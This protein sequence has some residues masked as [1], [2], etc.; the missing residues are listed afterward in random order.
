MFKV[1]IADD[2]PGMRL[3]L[4]KA[5]SKIKEVHILAEAESAD[6]VVELVGIHKPQAVFLDVEMGKK[7]GLEAAK[8][9]TDM[10]PKCMI[11]FVTAFQE[12][13]PEAFEIYAFDYL[14]KPFKMERLEETVKRMKLV[15]ANEQEFKPVT[16]EMSEEILIKDKDGTAFV[17][18]KEI[19]LVQRENRSTTIITKTHKYHTTETLSEI[20]AKLPHKL[21]LR[22]HKSYIIQ[23]SKIIK[24][25]PYGRWTYLVRLKGI[26]EDA[27]LT[28]EKADLLE[29]KFKMKIGI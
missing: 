2:E 16:N 8:L 6:Q 22:S 25:A 4:S 1:I 24:I 28:K 18:L 23:M 20:E 11:V 12:Y 14:V 3:L 9:I 21:F 19:I 10:D 17:P 13:M 5:L 7:T 15:Y 29:Q 26:E 27:L